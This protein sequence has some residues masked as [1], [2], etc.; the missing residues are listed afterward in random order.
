MDEFKARQNALRNDCRT[1]SQD[2]KQKKE[3]L[4][5]RVRCFYV[6]GGEGG[7]MPV[8]VSGRGIVGG[9]V[10]SGGVT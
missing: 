1:V 6:S 4:S 9:R 2:K 10:T 8:R 7:C 5:E 3:V